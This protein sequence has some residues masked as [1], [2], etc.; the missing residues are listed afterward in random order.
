MEAWTE[1]QIKT[2]SMETGVKKLLDRIAALPEGNHTIAIDGRCGAGKSTL[3]AYLAEALGAGVVH[4]DD[5]YLPMELRTPERLEEPGGNVYYERFREEVLPFLNRGDVFAY[6]RFDCSRM[7]LGEACRIPA[8]RF[9]VVEGAYSFHPRLGNYMALRVFL[10]VEPGVQR[11][12]IRRRN[13]QEGLKV[14]L[15]KWIP[16]EEAYFKAYGIREQADMI[17]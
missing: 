15:Q 5:F 1:I 3:A 11:E 4:M 2:Q 9:T 6:R 17:L 7:E 10:D 13:G 8:S 14:F 12:R 16:L